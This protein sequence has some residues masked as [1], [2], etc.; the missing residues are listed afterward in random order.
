MFA[1]LLKYLPPHLFPLE[2][3]G[4]ER[5]QQNFCLDVEGFPPNTAPSWPVSIGSKIDVYL[6]IAAVRSGPTATI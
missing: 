3:K 4:G 6:P 1:F 2:G 5:P